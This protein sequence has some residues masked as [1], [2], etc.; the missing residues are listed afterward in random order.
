MERVNARTLSALRARL[1]NSPMSSRGYSSRISEM[2][3]YDFQD[4]KTSLRQLSSP[5]QRIHDFR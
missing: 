4:Y 1:T 5:V 2:T 3:C